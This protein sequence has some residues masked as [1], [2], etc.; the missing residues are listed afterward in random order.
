MPAGYSKRSLA[1]KLGLKSGTSACFVNAPDHLPNLLGPLPKGMIVVDDGRGSLDY[2][3]V[4]VANA[5]ELR[6]RLP[7]LKRRLRTDG[8]LW[9]SWPKK[10]SKLFRDVTEDT[11]RDLALKIGLVDVKVCAVDEDWSALKLMYRVKDR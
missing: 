5:N 1:A 2:I 6:K 8:C 10:T 7:A 9:V 4:F 11:V 3:H